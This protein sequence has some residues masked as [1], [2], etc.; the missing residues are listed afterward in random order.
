MAS[1]AA[2]A[3]AHPLLGRVAPGDI[4]SADLETSSIDF[5]SAMTFAC[6]LECRGQRHPRH[7]FPGDHDERQ[8]SMSDILPL[9]SAIVPGQR[10]TAARTGQLFECPPSDMILLVASVFRASSNLTVVE[11]FYRSSTCDVTLSRASSN[12]NAIEEFFTV[13]YGASVSQSFRVL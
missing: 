13:R 3:S 4:G 12:L 7:L 5:T 10:M 2:T 8:G 11:E 9:V 1:P 6:Q